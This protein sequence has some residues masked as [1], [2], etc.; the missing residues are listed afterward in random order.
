MSDI[1]QDILSFTCNSINDTEGSHN[2][3]QQSLDFHEEFPNGKIGIQITKDINNSISLAYSPY[4][5]EPCLQI[6]KNHHVARKY[7]NLANS[8]AIITNGTAVLGLGDIGPLASLPVMEG[9]SA[10]FKSLGGID[11]FVHIINELDPHR[12]ADIIKKTS[13]PFAAINLEDIASPGC[14]ELCELLHDSP[15]PVF[16][17]DQHGT[18]IV[19]Y[20]AVKNYLHLHSAASVK[21]IKLVCLG[22]GA[23]AIASLNLLLELGIQRSNIWLFD[24][25]GLV[26]ENRSDIHLDKNKYKRIFAQKQ[27]IDISDA[28]LDA[29]IFLGTSSG[30]TVDGSM[31]ARMAH[32]PLIMALANPAPE[33]SLSDVTSV[34]KDAVYCS[35]RSDFPNQVNNVLCFPYLFRVVLDFNLHIDQKLMKAVGDAISSIAQ[36]HPKYGNN[37][38]IPAAFDDIVRYTMPMQI[39]EKLHL[40]SKQYTNYMKQYLRRIVPMVG[41]ALYTASQYM[42]LDDNAFHKIKHA[43]DKITHYW[44]LPSC[45][46][47]KVIKKS[48]TINASRDILLIKSNNQTYIGC[49]LQYLELANQLGQYANILV[50]LCD[51]NAIQHDSNTQVIAVYRDADDIYLAPDVD[52]ENAF[53]ASLLFVNGRHQ[54]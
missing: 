5:A 11:C 26:H 53:L 41:K 48:F 49:S 54:A 28:M 25:K 21:K 4:V 36:D 52:L 22:A 23:A 32:S 40:T 38:I 50:T 2:Y 35:G 27:K 16:H 33:I 51:F 9:K 6:A 18:A 12:M 20:A 34:R 24:S 37:Q 1:K 14:F 7:T 29:H 31:V 42:I 10:L 19:V 15:V 39:I 43:F 47:L 30:G 46:V 13:I 45:G 17:D 8:I 3:S 44:S